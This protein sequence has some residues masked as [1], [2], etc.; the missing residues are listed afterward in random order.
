MMLNLIWGKSSFLK[1]P[2]ACFESPQAPE[3]LAG[4]WAGGRVIEGGCLIGK[5]LGRQKGL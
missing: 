3:N 4:S 2:G 1:M 5:M